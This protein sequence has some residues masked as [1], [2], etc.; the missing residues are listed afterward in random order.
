MQ[1]PEYP[2]Q[3]ELALVAALN[4][5]SRY[6]C[7]CSPALAGAA[8]VQLRVVA[9]DVRF[10]EALRDCAEQL[11]CFWLQRSAAMEARQ[12]LH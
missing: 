3:P 1:M 9:D 7:C 11:A 4:L 5:I 10:S 8:A 12:P 6:S 2:E